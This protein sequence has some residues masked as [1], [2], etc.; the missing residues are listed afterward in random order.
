MKKLSI[1]FGIALVALIAFF[2][3]RSRREDDP[4]AAK[5]P[6]TGNLAPPERLESNAI[7]RDIRPPLAATR[8][9]ED[10]EQEEVE[11]V[12][13]AD[14]FDPKRLQAAREAFLGLIKSWES[15]HSTALKGTPGADEGGMIIMYL[16]PLDEATIASATRLLDE[17]GIPEDQRQ[18]PF[19]EWAGLVGKHR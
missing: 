15:Q 19:F 3:F 9:N 1:V 12:L 11:R 16:P 7:T 18:R 13:G 8:K 6:A 14:A 4:T 10:S 5:G 17:H 2:D